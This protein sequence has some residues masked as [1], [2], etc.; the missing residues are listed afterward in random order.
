MEDS[1]NDDASDD[2]LKWEDSGEITESSGKTGAAAAVGPHG[3]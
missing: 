2:E 3:S 1:D